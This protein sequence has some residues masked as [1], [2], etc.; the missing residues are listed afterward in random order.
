MKTCLCIL[1]LLGSTALTIVAQEADYC[2]DRASEAAY[3]ECLELRYLHTDGALNLLYQQALGMIDDLEAV[4]EEEAQPEAWRTALRAAQRAWIAFKDAECE[5]LA[6]LESWMAPQDDWLIL[7]DEQAKLLCRIRLT[8]A[9]V[10]DI[11]AHYNLTAEPAARAYSDIVQT[12]AVSGLARRTL[13]RFGEGLERHDWEEVLSFFNEE[14]YLDQRD[15]LGLSDAQI[16]LETLG[17]K[18]GLAGEKTDTHQERLNRIAD[19]IISETTYD[20]ARGMTVKGVVRL[21]DGSEHAF[22]MYWSEGMTGR[23]EVVVPVG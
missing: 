23:L 12:E 18:G 5:T 17:V 19:V 10:Q 9:R 11:A 6:P 2:L 3:N 7:N 13:Q 20:D 1:L 21:N 14:N 16:M 4:S 15:G 22:Q 8:E